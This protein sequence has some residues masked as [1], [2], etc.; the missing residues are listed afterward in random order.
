DLRQAAQSAARSGTAQLLQPRH[1]LFVLA[2]LKHV[3]Q[4]TEQVGREVDVDAGW[5]VVQERDALADTGRDQLARQGERRPLWRSSRARGRADQQFL[6]RDRSL[7]LRS[8]LAQCR[9]AYT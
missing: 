2:L 8:C 1:V 6:E 5:L 7:E 3:H 9:D 4:S